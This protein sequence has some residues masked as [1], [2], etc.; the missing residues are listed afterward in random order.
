MTPIRRDPPR[1]DLP[2]P[3]G[4]PFVTVLASTVR[5]DAVRTTLVPREASRLEVAHH[6]RHPPAA[7]PALEPER[8]GD[9]RS[10]RQDAY[11]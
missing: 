1:R 3:A 11:A 10:A 9:R 5:G 4:T 2:L 6:D 8:A 7:V